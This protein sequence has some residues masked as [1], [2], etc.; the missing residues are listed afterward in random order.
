MRAVL[1][2]VGE[3]ADL[4]IVRA[5][6]VLASAALQ[7]FF[8]TCTNDSL[9]IGF[10]S[11]A[12]RSS[13][14]CAVELDIGRAELA[15]AIGMRCGVKFTVTA[16][17][18]PRRRSPARSPARAGACPPNRAKAPRRAFAEQ[19]V[20]LRPAARAGNARFG[21]DGDVVHVDQL[22]LRERHQR[23]QRRGRITAGAGDQPRGAYLLAD[24]IRSGRRRLRPEA[25]GAVL[26]AVPLRVHA[27]VAEPEIR[28]HVEDLDGRIGGKD[29]GDDLLRRA[30]RQSAEHR[31]E[32]G[33]VDLFPFREPGRSSMKKCGNTSSIALPAWVLAVSA[34]S[35]RSDAAPAAA[36]R[37]R[38]CSRRRRECRSS[39]VVLMASFLQS[40]LH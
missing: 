3:N 38:R 20:L 16:E 33:P 24:R 28:R 29:G 31:I 32:F 1:D 15:P 17:R 26:V 19:R 30:V 18:R 6:H 11:A 12:R 8:A 27:H 23:Q 7:P 4:S 39:S 35:R 37:R 40:R 25:P 10:A 5:A 34:V 14:A 2:A 13:A 36:P 9:A 22:C 21:V